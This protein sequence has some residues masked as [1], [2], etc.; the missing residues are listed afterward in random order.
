MPN[1]SKKNPRKL[2]SLQKL[3]R[4]IL[5]FVFALQA[6]IP[7]GYMPS[8]WSSGALLALCPEGLSQS[9]VKILSISNGQHKH[10]Q[11]LSFH[12]MNE[13][14]LMEQASVMHC[15][16]ETKRLQIPDQMEIKT[17]NDIVIND[18]HKHEHNSYWNDHC[19]Y[20]ILNISS[21]IVLTEKNDLTQNCFFSL[22]ANEAKASWIAYQT[23]RQYHSRAPPY[24]S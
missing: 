4:C 22:K 8:S 9:L 18:H 21:D 20:G 17:L 11:Q 23:L 7:A 2:T 10:S 14:Q 19:S 3:K 13:K 16:T 15:H 12:A 1:I 5:V 24:L 6:L